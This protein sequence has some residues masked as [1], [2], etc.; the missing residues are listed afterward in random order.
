MQRLHPSAQ[1]TVSK[2][3]SHTKYRD[4]EAVVW[5]TLQQQRVCMYMHVSVCV[6]ERDGHQDDDGRDLDASGA[7]AA[8]SKS[9]AKR[10]DE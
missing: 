5:P 2:R 4:R 8:A 10:N 7:E 6:E 1:N 3:L 9:R